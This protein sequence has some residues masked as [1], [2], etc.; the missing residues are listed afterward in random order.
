MASGDLVVLDELTFPQIRTK[1]F[2]SFLDAFEAKSALILVDSRVGFSQGG[3]A[4][5]RLACP[6]PDPPHRRQRGLC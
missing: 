1:D 4:P 2:V 5:D 3:L 6:R